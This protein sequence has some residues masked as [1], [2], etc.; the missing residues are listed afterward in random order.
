MLR[1]GSEG[2]EVSKLQRILLELGYDLNENGVDGNFGQK[3][4]MLFVIFNMII[5]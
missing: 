1:K 3:P 5:I 4:K 2:P